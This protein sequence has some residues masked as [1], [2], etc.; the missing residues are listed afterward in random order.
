MNTQRN[1]LMHLENTLIMYGIYNAETLEKLVK[2]IHALHSRQSLYESLFAGQ[3]SAAYEAYSQ[4]HGAYSIQYYAVNSMLYLH[5]IKDK[6][7]KIYNELILQLHIYAKAVRI[8]AKG[9]LLI[10]LVMSLKLKEI[11][12]L[13]KEALI[14]TNPDYDIMIKRLHLYY[15]MKLVTFGIDRKEIL[16]YN[17]QDLYYLI[18]NNC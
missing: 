4:M 18:L 5:T 15:K 3:T 14:K 13:V 1:K 8:L 10:S 6:Y 11:L 12:D 7:V 9:Y 16:L 17:F 2:T